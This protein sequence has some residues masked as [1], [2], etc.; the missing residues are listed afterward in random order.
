MYLVFQ[1][2]RKLNKHGALHI[3]KTLTFTLEL[4][5]AN[6]YKCIQCQYKTDLPSLH[7]TMIDTAECDPEL[8]CFTK[9][10]KSASSTCKTD[11]PVPLKQHVNNCHA[12]MMI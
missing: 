5:F 12:S 2:Y 9:I 11:S 6:C 1:M 10:D 3:L 7:N 8:P 4:V